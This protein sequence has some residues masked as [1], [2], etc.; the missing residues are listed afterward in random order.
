SKQFPFG[1]YSLEVRSSIITSNVRTFPLYFVT[2]GSGDGISSDTA[3]QSSGL[4]V[5][6]DSPTQVSTGSPFR[7][8]VQVSQGGAL[9]NA[10]T[11][12]ELVA[13]LGSSHI[14]SGDSANLTAINLSGKFY[15]LHEG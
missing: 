4:V 7:I 12:E 15:K 1:A 5:K 8:F 6:L 14:H 10:N 11:D 2:D 3:S 13:M 9:V